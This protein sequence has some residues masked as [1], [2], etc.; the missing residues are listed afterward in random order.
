MIGPV[1]TW[2]FKKRFEEIWT[3]AEKAAEIQ[4]D[5]LFELLKTASKTEYG[6]QHGFK[7][8]INYKQRQIHLLEALNWHLIY[9][10][11]LK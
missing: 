4:N 7:N 9:Q 10:Q 6:L 2:Y 1:L 5:T 8:I 11:L 3:N